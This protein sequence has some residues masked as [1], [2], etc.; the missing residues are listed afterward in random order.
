MVPE[1]ERQLRLSMDISGVLGR[2]NTNNRYNLKQSSPSQLKVTIQKMFTV[3]YGPHNP[4]KTVAYESSNMR[5]I[6]CLD[7]GSKMS[8]VYPK[9]PSVVPSEAKSLKRIVKGSLGEK[10]I[11]F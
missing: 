2:G 1:L 11:I 10:N 9:P 5:H 6:I 4:S 8:D 7:I 3:T